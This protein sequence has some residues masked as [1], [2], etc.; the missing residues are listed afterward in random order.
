M[1]VLR[2]DVETPYPELFAWWAITIT[3]GI[4]FLVL[5]SAYLYVGNRKRREGSKGGLALFGKLA[6]D[7]VFVWSLLG[8]LVL[9]IVSI[10]NG[11]SILFACGNIVVEVFLIIYIVTNR[12]KS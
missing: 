1:Q 8:L 6:K 4:I 5:V 11:S 2:G 9:Y 3:G 7:F 10:G 12:A